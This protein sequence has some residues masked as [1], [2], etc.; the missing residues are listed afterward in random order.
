MKVWQ[1]LKYSV[2]LAFCVMLVVQNAEISWNTPCLN[3]KC[4]YSLLTFWTFG[5]VDIAITPNSFTG[6]SLKFQF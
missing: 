5:R 2:I 1:S 4:G 3:N 6:K